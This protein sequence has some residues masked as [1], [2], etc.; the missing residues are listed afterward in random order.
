MRLLVACVQACNQLASASE[1]AAALAALQA[2]GYTTYVHTSSCGTFQ[3]VLSTYHGTSAPH[4][5]ADNLAAA[6][7]SMQDP[8]VVVPISSKQSKLNMTLMLRLMNGVVNLPQQC[9]S[10][11]ASDASDPSS[12]ATAVDCS[13]VR[14]SSS[15]SLAIVS[16]S[17]VVQV[18][19]HS[20][21]QPPSESYG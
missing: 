20:G 1:V 5:G 3:Y 6:G 21:I 14:T 16:G 7:Y 10:S 4:L 9:R 11:P 8:M 17:Y 2:Q 13:T 12:A 15:I 19:L 18:L